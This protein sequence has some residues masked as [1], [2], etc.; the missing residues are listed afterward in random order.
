MKLSIALCVTAV[1]ARPGVLDKFKRLLKPAKPAVP[2]KPLD[3]ANL[4]TPGTVEEAK[5]Y[6][7]YAGLAYCPAETIW[8]WSCRHCR[9][10]G[11]KT[12][13]GIYVGSATETKSVLLVDHARQEL[14]LAFRG[15]SN[16][17]NKIED[18]K[19]FKKEFFV[20]KVHTGFRNCASEQMDAYQHALQKLLKEFPSYTLVLTG[21]SLG[22]AIAVLAAVMV[23]TQWQ[24]D[25]RRMHVVTYGQPRVGD[26]AFVT[27]VNAQPWKT[28]RVVNENDRVPHLT[29]QGM[30]YY[31]HHTELH[32]RNG[33]A[34]FCRTSEPEDGNCS[35]SLSDYSLDSHLYAFNV[36]LGRQ[37]C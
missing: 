23:H 19:V 5:L 27:W 2:A 18:A 3:T 25:P 9:S 28:T 15:T 20:G 26:L 32:L 33:T 8:D 30:G 7:H 11:E 31:H 29:F 36:R 35:T 21:H 14:V 37:G 22:G 13:T 24:V 10:L 16:Q 12:V 17:R 4:S 6:T 1:L 34:H